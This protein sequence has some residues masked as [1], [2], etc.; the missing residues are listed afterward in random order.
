MTY[1][2]KPAEFT[3]KEHAMTASEYLV[4]PQI[5]K[6]EV[7]GKNILV[8]WNN[9]AKSLAPAWWFQRMSEGD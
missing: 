8:Y 3:T 4:G 9:G 6:K 2:N 5:I 1:L 7:Q